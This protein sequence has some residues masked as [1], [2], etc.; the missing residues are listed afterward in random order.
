MPPSTPTTAS[1]HRLPPEFRNLI[2]ELVLFGND[3]CPHETKTDFS[4][5][6]PPKPSPI[7]PLTRINRDIRAETLP[8]WYGNQKLRVASWD[9]QQ[10]P[11]F[12]SWLGV[13]ES[14]LHYLKLFVLDICLLHDTTCIWNISGPRD[15][16]SDVA[17]VFQGTYPPRT[18]G[19]AFDAKEQACMDEWVRWMKP[20]PDRIGESEVT[21]EMCLEIVEHAEVWAG[22][23][24]GCKEARQYKRD[25]ARAAARDARRARR[26]RMAAGDAEEG[27][28]ESDDGSKIESEDESK[29]ES[30]DESDDRQ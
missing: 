22:P 28:T 25:A 11:R 16:I 17:F 30:E 18:L 20:M 10:A 15:K 5:F 14:H 2:Y 19:P 4:I 3:S 13:Y 7:P 12:K 1:L 27:M 8:M 6:E 21:A 23:W 9:Y 29:D 24:G 26:A